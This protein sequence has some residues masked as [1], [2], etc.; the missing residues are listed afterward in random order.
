VHL[1]GTGPGDPGL[2]TLRALRLMQ[3][4]DVVLYDRLV[5]DDILRLIS[6]DALL[7]YV[8]KRSG[9]HHRTQ[10]EINELIFQ[11]ARRGSRVL[12]LKGG[13]PNMFGRG[14][15]EMEYL[16]AL[17]VA[18]HIV[19]GITA[20]AGIGAELQIPLT[21]RGVANSTVF[22][23]VRYSRLAAHTA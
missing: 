17:G 14:G 4:A 2:L 20:A 13:D 6:H 22:L 12:R 15:E 5:S 19:P 18:V 10:D 1:V 23:T 16:R 21:T 3:S 11:F 8:G 7:V 9:Y